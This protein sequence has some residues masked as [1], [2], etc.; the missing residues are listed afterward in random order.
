M[1]S[2]ILGQKMRVKVIFMVL[3]IFSAFLTVSQP[4]PPPPPP[5]PS[6]PYP[7]PPVPPSPEEPVPAPGPVPGP[8]GGPGI[9]P[10]TIPSPDVSEE[11][12]PSAFNVPKEPGV[13][14]L[15]EP[16]EERE[17]PTTYGP[18]ALAVSGNLIYIWYWNRWS[19]GPASVCLNAWRP[20]AIYIATPGYYTLYE[21]YYYPGS[22]WPYRVNTLNLGYRSYGWYMLWFIADALGWHALVLKSS[23]GTGYDSNVLWVY[24][25]SCGPAPPPGPA[26]CSVSLWVPSTWYP[27][28]STVTVRYV[29]YGRASVLRLTVVGPW[30]WIT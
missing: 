5:E 25:S 9:P 26:A 8:E 30:T 12:P 2:V 4:L 15:E 1:G 17:I 20:L 14:P 3:T 21:Y 23:W 18:T 6:P 7:A 10:A 27:A 28:G 19:L 16:K 24:V 11:L 22:T 13:Y 29:A